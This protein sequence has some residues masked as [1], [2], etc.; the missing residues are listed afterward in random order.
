MSSALIV[1]IHGRAKK[2]WVHKGG[3]GTMSQARNILQSTARYFVLI[4]AATDIKNKAKEIGINDIRTLV[5][6][7]RSITEIYL[8]SISADKKIQ[9][10]R[11]AKVLLEMGVTPEELWQE[12]IRQM[13]E[14][15]PIIKGKDNYIKSEMQKIEAFVKGE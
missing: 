8:E 15:S 2:S 7:G 13:P 12:V 11:E 1:G 4:R 3:H 9:K 5:E 10:R 14:L 6:A